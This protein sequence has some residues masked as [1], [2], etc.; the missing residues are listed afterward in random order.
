MDRAR[1]HVRPDG[2]EVRQCGARPGSVRRVNHGYRVGG[3]WVHARSAP[4]GAEVVEVQEDLPATHVDHDGEDPEE[5]WV[6]LGG[7]RHHVPCRG[8]GLVSWF[9][10][11][12]GAIKIFPA[13]PGGCEVE[14]VCRP[15]VPAPPDTLPAPVDDGGP[16]G[17]PRG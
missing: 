8:E 7:I 4:E 13:L 12:D 3:R 6:T 10:D 2:R 5:V 11:E 15:A 14:V 16:K 1:T 9:R 17:G